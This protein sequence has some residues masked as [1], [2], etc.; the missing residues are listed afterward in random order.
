MGSKPS[1]R[2]WDSTPSNTPRRRRSPSPHRRLACAAELADVNDDLAA[3]DEEVER[4]LRQGDAREAV[5]V[6]ARYDGHAPTDKKLA[7]HVSRQERMESLL[8][9]ITSDDWKRAPGAPSARALARF[10]RAAS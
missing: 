7:A 3:I 9:Y 1:R 4:E 6:D 8:S 5:K 10:L 2:T